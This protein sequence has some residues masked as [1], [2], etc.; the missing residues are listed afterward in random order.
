MKNLLFP[1]CLG[2]LVFTS[3]SPMY[4]SPNT[5]NVPMIA[6]K[7]QFVGTLAGT[8]NQVDVQTAYNISKS[9][10]VQLNGG[11]I[12]PKDLDNGNGGS[13][14]FGEAGVGYYKKLGNALVFETYALAGVGAM[15]NHLP[16]TIDSAKTTTGNISAGLTRYSIQPAIGFVTANLSIIFSTRLSSLNYSNITGS[17]VYKNEDQVAYL[18]HNANTYLAE[19]A[20]TARLGTRS[21]QLQ[22]QVG[23]SFNLTNNTFLQATGYVTLGLHLRLN[24]AN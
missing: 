9:I 11:L 15:E 23:R 21:L 3:C 18:K 20:I 6:E 4:Y 1:L 16:S 10:G 5:H 14:K 17:L 24:N 13:G 7:D 12:L 22:A 2:A 8:G 19:P